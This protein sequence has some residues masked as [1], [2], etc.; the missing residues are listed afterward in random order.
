MSRSVK[1]LAALSLLTPVALVA[2]A[3]QADASVKVGSNARNAY[4]QVTRAG[5][6]EVTWVTQRGSR[7]H[8]LI[9]PTGSLRFGSTVQKR[10]VARRTTAVHLPLKAQVWRTP[11]GT[12]WALQRWRRIRT[13]PVELRFSRWRG[14]P[15]Q[16]A[17]RAVCCKWR[18][19]TIKG[20][21]R[22]HR[23]G[24]YGYSSTPSGS[25]LDRF[26]RNVFM[27]THRRG[28]WRR[29]MGVLTHPSEGWYKL[30]MRRHWRG[31]RYRATISGPNRAWTL[32]PD[33]RAYT[34]SK[35][36]G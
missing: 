4:L 7:K 30:W 27:D 22:Y 19:E 9:R 25:P 8:V 10:N 11:D 29:M 31:N 14:R 16:L 26:G 6:A 34:R 32:A 23:K 24:I 5:S 28:K 20:T 18:S 36:W 15:T 21:A 17:L 12:F 13:G 2:A 33:A 3:E 35:R 1:A